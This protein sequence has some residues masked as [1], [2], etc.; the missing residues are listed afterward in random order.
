MALMRIVV[1]AAALLYSAPAVVGADKRDEVI[2]L[3]W[4][5]LMPAGEEERLTKL[6]DEFFEELERRAELLRKGDPNSLS[7]LSEGGAL[8][9]MPQIGTFN[10]VEDLNGAQVRIP[11][12]IV[13][14]DF[15]AGDE[16]EEFLLVPYYGACIHTPP[17]PPNQIV[18][19]RASPPVKLA[20]IW[21]PFWAEG[22]LT[23]E[24]VRNKTGDAAYALQLDRLLPYE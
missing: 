5:D 9:E 15:D 2:Q 13:P 14:L 21:L 6:Y 10:T 22:E 20:N 18:Y 16:Y 23:A 4:D 3:R 8:D 1:C 17:P 24:A 11:G 19:V 12:Y 7:A